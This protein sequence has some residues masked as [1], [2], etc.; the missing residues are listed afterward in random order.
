MMHSASM[1]CAYCHDV[2]EEHAKCD[3]RQAVADRDP[4]SLTG[5]LLSLEL[6]HRDAAGNGRHVVVRRSTGEA[7]TTGRALEVW[8]WLHE[9]AR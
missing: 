3:Q 9:G 2:F 8:R 6:V 4:E 7:V 5:R 1:P